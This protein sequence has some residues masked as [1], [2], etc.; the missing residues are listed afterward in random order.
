MD[1]IFEKEAKSW[2]AYPSIDRSD[3]STYGSNSPEFFSVLLPE[4]FPLSLL[5]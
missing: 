5:I 4:A 2:D 3:Q 1:A